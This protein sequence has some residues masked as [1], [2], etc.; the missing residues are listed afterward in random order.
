MKQIKEIIP[1]DKT[2]Q[3]TRLSEKNKKQGQE[4]S[5]KDKTKISKDKSKRQEQGKQTRS[6][7]NI[8]EQNYSFL[9]QE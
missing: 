4:T 3:A 6:D 8:K 2:D 9:K 1:R 7:A 5:S